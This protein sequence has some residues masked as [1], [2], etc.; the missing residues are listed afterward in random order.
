MGEGEDQKESKSDDPT[1]AHDGKPPS[2]AA[3]SPA[4][5]DITPNKEAP[6]KC[7]SGLTSL[8]GLSL[9][10]VKDKKAARSLKVFVAGFSSSK[11]TPPCR[12]FRSLI[13]LNE[14][15]PYF[16][17]LESASVE[18]DL[19]SVAESVK[20]FKAALN[21]LLTMTRNASTALRNGVR[22]AA[23]KDGKV[24]GKANKASSS[25]QI[26]PTMTKLALFERGVEKGTPAQ[27]MDIGVC[28]L[29]KPMDTITEPLV[30][31]GFSSDDL[32]PLHAAGIA[33]NSKFQGSRLPVSDRPHV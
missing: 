25:A 3:A 32:A 28:M 15:D 9:A 29:T 6:P 19:K 24:G 31:K 8:E 7:P 33:F 22:Q 10:E 2:V 18:A 30:M 17:K 16:A 27:V 12:S 13:T 20:P 4:L 23:G 14:F 1:E 5:E 11:A 21:D 26:N